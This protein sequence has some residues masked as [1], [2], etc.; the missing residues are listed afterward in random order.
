MR[1]LGTKRLTVRV[2]PALAEIPPSLVTSGLVLGAGGHELTYSYHP[3]AAQQAVPELL[4]GLRGAGIRVNDVETS[5]SSLEDIFV[6]L[7]RE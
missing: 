2:E 6:N 5:Q 4:D 1:K 3:G 7:V